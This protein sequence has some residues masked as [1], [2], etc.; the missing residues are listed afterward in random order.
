MRR[1]VLAGAAVALCLVAL[2]GWLLARDDGL[3]RERVERIERQ[4]EQTLDH[5]PGRERVR[6]RPA[7]ADVRCSGPG[8]GEDV[9]L[10]GE[11]P[12]ISVIC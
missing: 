11:H 8:L 3:D 2:G 9:L 12:E 6:C 1:W 4:L 7:G 10:D 5:C